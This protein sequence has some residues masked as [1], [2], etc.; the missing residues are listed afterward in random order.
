MPDTIELHG[1]FPPF[2]ARIREEDIEA[3]V[4]RLQQ[5]KKGTVKETVDTIPSDWQV[6]AVVRRKLIELIVRRAAYV[7][8]TIPKAI[9]QKCWPDKLFDIG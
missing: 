5:L 6:P 2:A 9:A 4:A 7:A 3:A 8:E 1:L